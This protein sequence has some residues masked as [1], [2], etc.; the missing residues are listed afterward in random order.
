MAAVPTNQVKPLRARI[1]VPA[2][3]LDRGSK[4][5]AI[6]QATVVLDRAPTLPAAFGAPTGGGEVKRKL[7]RRRHHGTTSA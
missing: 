1:F 2:L 4:D 3:A 6:T 5:A 7:G